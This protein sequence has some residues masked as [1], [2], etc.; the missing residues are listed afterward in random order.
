MRKFCDELGFDPVILPGLE[1]SERTRFHA[2]QDKGWFDDVDA[3]MTSK[4]N[5]MSYA[6]N[7]RP[8]TDD[9]PYFSQFLTRQSLARLNTL[10]GTRAIP[11]LEISYLVLI[12]TTLQITV[13]AL[14]LIV[15]PLLKAGRAGRMPTLL[16][17]GGIGIGYMFIEMV[18]I[19]RFVMYLGNDVYAAATV[20]SAMMIFSGSG[21]YVSARL[22]TVSHYILGGIPFLILIAVLAL[23]SLLSVTIFLSMAGRIGIMLLLIAPLAFGMGMPFALGISSI[24]DDDVPWA[25]GINGCL[26]VIGTPLATVIAVELG[27][28]WVMILAACA[29]GV[30]FC[31]S[32]GY[33]Q[34]KTHEG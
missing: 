23:P 1:P 29:Y 20:I 2:L 30:A 26:S 5:T 33:D 18:L 11:F 8:A 4:R 14:V 28:T 16:Y 6:F 3:V 12:V 15:L 9:R 21:S 19:Q 22:R 34:K 10:Y 32:A 27:F 31:S 7:I 25:W 13:L 24:V 17:F